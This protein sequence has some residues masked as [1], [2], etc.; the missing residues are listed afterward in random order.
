[1]TLQSCHHSLVHLYLPGPVLLEEG[2]RHSPL[3]LASRH[4]RSCSGNLP[5]DSFLSHVLGRGWGLS[6]SHRAC[7]W[8][9]YPLKTPGNVCWE[10]EWIC[11]LT[12]LPASLVLSEISSGALTSTYH[13][14]ACVHLPLPSS[15]PSSS[16]RCSCPRAGSSRS[17]REHT[18]PPRSR[19]LSSWWPP[20]A[21]N[22]ET[23]VT[24]RPRSR[25]RWAGLQKPSQL[26]LPYRNNSDVEKGT[27]AMH[28]KSTPDS[29]T[30]A[31]CMCWRQLDRKQRRVRELTEA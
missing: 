14:P 3:S 5:R 31:Q 15:L 7:S 2:P 23:A 18:Q 20:R 6:Q 10:H 22:P 16:S 30:Q 1:M 8:A 28:F 17:D 21:E 24:G 26:S 12:S 9:H 19:D 4:K 13:G 27:T 29:S 25:G 11:N